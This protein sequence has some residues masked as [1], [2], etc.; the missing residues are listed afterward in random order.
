MPTQLKEI[1]FEII[2]PKKPII[3]DIDSAGIINFL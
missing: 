1:E 3:T 2:S